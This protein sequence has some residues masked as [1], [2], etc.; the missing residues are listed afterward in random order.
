M[1]QKK[2]MALLTLLGSNVVLVDLQER[3]VEDRNAGISF[4]EEVSREHR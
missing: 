1:S 2:K 4:L 3:T